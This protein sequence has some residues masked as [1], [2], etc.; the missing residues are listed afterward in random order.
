MS[1]VSGQVT[2]FST[3]TVM[4]NFGITVNDLDCYMGSRTGTVETD[5]LLSVGHANS[6]NQFCRMQ[7]DGKAQKD[8]SHC[9]CAYDSAGNTV[10][11]ASVTAGWGTSILTFNVAVV[12]ANYS[13][14][15]VVRT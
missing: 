12:N 2:F 3:G 9:I 11:Q 7:A 6:G 4:V 14:D 15:A 1:V 8:T 10:L 13:W 5:G